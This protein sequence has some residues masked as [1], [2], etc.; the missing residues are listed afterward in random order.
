MPK[1]PRV[2]TQKTLHDFLPSNSS[3]V[4][5]AAN[6]ESIGHPLSSPLH[7]KQRKTKKTRA[8]QS[9]GSDTGSLDSTSDI[10]AIPFEPDVIEISD[11]EE[12]AKSSPR[13]PRA[14]RRVRGNRARSSEDDAEPFAG[15]S[16]EDNI[17][18]P[19]T[20]KDKGK[21][22]E[23]QRKR[24][25]EDSDAEEDIQ[26]KRRKFIRGSRPLTPEPTDLMEELDEDKI[27]DTRLRTR[28]KRSTYL[29]NLEKMKRKKRGEKVSDSDE[30][31]EESDDEPP[32]KPFKHA[33]PGAVTIDDDSDSV[34]SPAAEDEED[35]FIIEDDENAPLELPAEFSMSTYQDLAHHFKIICQLFV[36]LAVQE[37]DD[38]LEFMEQMSKEQYFSVPLQITRR[39]IDGARDSIVASSVWSNEYKKALRTYPKFEVIHLQFSVPSCDACR[40]GGRISTLS[41]RLSGEPYDRL[42]YKPIGKKNNS[43]EDSEPSMNEDEDNDEAKKVYHLGRFCAR[44]TRVFHEFVHWEYHLFHALAREVDDL[45]QRLSNKKKKPGERLY[46]PVA[47]AGGMQP[48]ENIEDADEVMSWLDSRQIISRE[49]QRLRQ[50]MDSAT[51]LEVASRRGEDQD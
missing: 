45:R 50:M 13:R 8:I 3:P 34:E 37:K 21:V 44:R 51:N 47:Y 40:L 7:K 46:V 1:K 38:R 24:V 10:G 2:P 36:H 42:T 15:I 32:T 5:P 28:E 23:K 12:E 30:D 14:P 4:R 31:E 48:P 11:S 25:V 22:V 26:P 35:T 9:D 43:D 19:V 17:G 20:W 18:L 49:I 16:E 39:K 33:R 6:T 29:K 27:L 41:G